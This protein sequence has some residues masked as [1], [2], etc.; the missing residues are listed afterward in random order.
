MSYKKLFMAHCMP[1]W[2][3]DVILSMSADKG[4]RSE[5]SISFNEMLRSSA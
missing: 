1:F 5:E 4:R 3:E 2:C